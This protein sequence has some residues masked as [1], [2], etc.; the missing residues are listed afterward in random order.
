MWTSYFKLVDDSLNRVAGIT[1]MVANWK[2][3]IQE[4]STRA[5]QFGSTQASLER[6]C[7][8]GPNAPHDIPRKASLGDSG[9]ND[10]HIRSSG[11]RPSSRNKSALRL[12]PYLVVT[13]RVK[14][15]PKPAKGAPNLRTK[16]LP[17][18]IRTITCATRLGVTR[19]SASASGLSRAVQGLGV[20]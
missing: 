20:L 18:C 13:I 4:A 19:D 11:D 15:A 14:W 8:V 1:I 3:E 9:T 16:S 7:M 5:P 10:R 12:G 2:R 17:N 6:V